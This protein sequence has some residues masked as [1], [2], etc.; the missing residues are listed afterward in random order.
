MVE[1]LTR[2]GVRF[3][4]NDARAMVRDGQRLWLVGVDDPHYYRSHNLEEAFKTVPPGEFAVFVAHT[5]ELY[6]DAARFGARLYLCGHTHAGQVCLPLVGAVF[7]HTKA[8]RR[9]LHGVWEHQ[10][11]SG[12]T[13]AG[14]GVSGLDVRFG[15][16]GEVVCL[17]L[18]KGSPPEFSDPIS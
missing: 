9:L 6:R 17:T 14:A 18:K 7:T 13:T 16:R 1:P 11:M 2:R 5:P 12:Y 4:L 3:L 10:G 15:C 8:S